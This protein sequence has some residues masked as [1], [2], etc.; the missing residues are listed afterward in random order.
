MP[1]LLPHVL[2]TL[3]LLRTAAAGCHSLA[4]FHDE[5]VVVCTVPKSNSS[6]WRRMLRYIAYQKNHT[7]HD[8]CAWWG[9]GGC[10]LDQPGAPAVLSSEADALELIE[11]NYTFA[12]FMRSPVDRVFSMHEGFGHAG[13]PQ[14]GAMRFDDFLSQLESGKWR[15]NEHTMGALELCNQPIGR[16]RPDW[17]FWAGAEDPRET[18]QR[19]HDFVH[20][21][22]GAEMYERVCSGWTSL[23]CPL[24]T[25]ADVFYTPV[26]TQAEAHGRAFRANGTCDGYRTRINSLYKKDA[27]AYAQALTRAYRGA[28][29]MSC[30]ISCNGTASCTA[31]I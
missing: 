31:A 14:R 6:M 28:G 19:A 26:S 17:Q 22:F 10:L 25:G 8:R 12:H 24:G 23:G 29:R 3:V 5:R 13:G 7:V 4:V 1:A 30:P 18:Q 9:T 11:R 16:A 27:H 15:G 20:A 2:F 21:L